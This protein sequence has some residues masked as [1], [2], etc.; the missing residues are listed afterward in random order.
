MQ[1]TQNPL[2]M[3]DLQTPATHE[4]SLVKRVG[5]RLESARRLSTSTLRVRAGAWQQRGNSRSDTWR[6]LVVFSEQ[7]LA[8]LCGK[9]AYLKPPESD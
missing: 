5:Q 3:R 2:P 4:L 7:K 1:G 8:Y 9:T 6:H